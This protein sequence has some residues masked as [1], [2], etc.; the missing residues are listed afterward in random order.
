MYITMG[1][2]S[3]LQFQ[4]VP[5]PVRGASSTLDVMLLSNVESDTL[6][7]VQVTVLAYGS[8]RRR[9]LSEASDAAFAV[10]SARMYASV[11]SLSTVATHARR[12][13]LQGGAQDTVQVRPRLS[14][15]Q[16]TRGLYS[17][18]CAASPHLTAPRCICRSPS[19]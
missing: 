17:A 4:R 9:L 1:W 11:S 19:T 2:A 10:T 8:S 14:C 15:R 6:M 12:N 16:R 7:S 18:P 13:L 3:I 5:E